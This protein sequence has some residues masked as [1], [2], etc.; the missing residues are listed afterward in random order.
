MRMIKGRALMAICGVGWMLAGQEAEAVTATQTISITQPTVSTSLTD[1]VTVT[2][3]TG[4]ASTSMSMSASLPTM[5]GSTTMT[6][7]TG[8]GTF[9]LS[10]SE[11][12]S[13]SVSVSLFTGSQTMSLFT[14]TDS[15]TMSL[16]TG[17]LTISLITGT[18][19]TTFSLPTGTASET[20]SLPTGTVTS[21][22]TTTYTVGTGSGSTTLTGTRSIVTGTVSYSLNTGTA[23]TTMTVPTGTDSASITLSLP[24]RTS[25]MSLPTGTSTTTMT[26][27]T[28]TSTASATISLP[29]GTQ[30]MS[31]T[32]SKS[33]SA[34]FSLP[35]LNNY[36]MSVEPA[37]FV[38][39]QEIRVQLKTI[40]DGV[41]SNSSTNRIQYDK[42]LFNVTDVGS[43][44]VRMYTWSS[45]YTSNCELYKG[46]TPLAERNEFGM[47]QSARYEGLV[48]V[49]SAH[50]TFPAPS[51]ATKFVI[52]FKHK[53]PQYDFHIPS[54]PDQM[55]DVWQVFSTSDG[56]YVFQAAESL[57]WYYLPDP[58]V[59]QYAIIQLLSQEPAWN[60]TYA[61]SSCLSTNA[62]CGWGDNLKIVPK[63]MACTYEYQSFDHAYLGS[64]F[65]GTDGS[66]IG[67]GLDSLKEGATA[68]GVGAFGTQFANPLV[69]TWTSWGT[70]F[71]ANDENYQGTS[72][73]S[74]PSG[75]ETSH[76]YAYVR[77][78]QT[79]GS[80][81]IC[82]SS[83]QQRISWKG[84]N[85]TIDSV[86]MW[87]K[88]FRCTSAA[89]CA[90]NDANTHFATVAEEVGWSMFDLSA[91][92]WGEIVFD[93]SGKGQLSNKAASSTV[94]V[95]SPMATADY[96]QVQTTTANYWAPAGG[97]YFRIVPSSQFTE[98]T[99]TPRVHPFT[100]GVRLGSFPSVGC[101]SR[102]YDVATS[103]ASSTS[104]GGQGG[105]VDDGA[106]YPIGS[107]DLTGDPTL[108]SPT[109]DAGAQSATY[110]SL[111]VPGEQEMWHVCYRRTC[112][113]SGATCAKNSGMRVLPF[114]YMGVGSTPTKWHHLNGNYP[115]T[116]VLAPGRYNES[117]SGAAAGTTIIGDNG[118]PP[119]VTWYTNDTRTET[120]GPIVVER[121]SSTQNKMKLDS[122]AWN[123]VRDWST[124]EDNL[125]MTVGST[126]RLVGYDKPC[127]YPGFTGAINQGAKNED[128]GMVECNSASAEA[129]DNKDEMWN[130]MGSASNLNSV[131]NMAFYITV[132]EIANYR[133][134]YRLGPWNWREIS[135]SSYREAWNDA[136]KPMPKETLKRGD[137]V[138]PAW[139]FTPTASA[140]SHLSL[141]VAEDR[142]QFEALFIV[143]DTQGSL[144]AKGR[145][146]CSGG[147]ESS[148]DVLRLVPYGSKCDINP[149]QWDPLL[150]D[151]HLSLY[152][153]KQGASATTTSGLYYD[154]SAVTP[155][156]LAKPTQEMCGGTCSSTNAM[157][158][159]LVKKTPDL[160]DDIVP[161]DHTY[162]GSSKL[163]ATVTIP[164]YNSV[165]AAKNFYTVCYKQME[166][167]NW[168]IFNN[169][170]EVK[171][172]PAMSMS[173][174]ARSQ[175]LVGGEFK[176]FK[177]T[178]TDMTLPVNTAGTG[179]HVGFYAKLVPELPH[180]DNNNC[181]NQPGDT[182][183]E[184]Y[185]AATSK[186]VFIAGG[187]NNSMYFYLTVPQKP[188]K[189]VLCVQLRKTAEDS[190]S[191]W[192]PGGSTSYDYDVLDNGIRWYV[193][194]GAQPTNNGLSAVKLVRCTPTDAG[195]NY[196]T[197][198]ETFNTNPDG[199]S[200]KI[201]AT[202]SP[203]SD[204]SSL[205]SPWGASTHVGVEG[206]GA[207]GVK[208]LGPNDGPADVAE[209]R[210]TLPGV[211][212]DA[213]VQY[214]VC[215][216]TLLNHANIG[217]A[218][219]PRWVEVAQ[220]MGM[221]EQVRIT[222][223]DTS[224]S[225]F[226]T[227]KGLMKSWTMDAAL[228]PA[229]SLFTGPSA[230][231]VGF[232]GASTRYVSNPS[233]ASSSTA[234]TVTTGF[235][236]NSYASLVTSQKSGNLFK[237]VKVGGPGTRYPEG[238]TW[239]QPSK[240]S[241]ASAADCMGPA[242]ATAS[243]TGTCSD[244]DGSSDTTDGS[245]VCPQL[246]DVA[247]ATT[248]SQ[249]EAVFHIPL[250]PGKYLVCYKV[251]HSSI[252][253]ENPWLWL[254]SEANNDYGLYSH[255]TFLE[256]EVAST[257]SNI[258]AFDL[259][260]MP[261]TSGDGSQV[262]VSS[263]CA[264][265]PQAADEGVPCS[266]QN[267][268]GFTTDLVTIV[269]DTQV[270][271]AP[272]VA[273]GGGTSSSGQ[274]G[275]RWFE[276][277]RTTNVSAGVSI[278]WSATAD[279]FALPP[280]SY[281][282][283][284]GQYKLCVYKAGE[285]QTG[286]FVDGA[287]EYVAKQGVVYQL[288]NRGSADNGGGSGFWRDSTGVGA[289]AQLLVTSTLQFNSSIRFMEY[290]ANL[291]T[292]YGAS[293]VSTD[294]VTDTM[295][296]TVSRTPLLRSGTSV[297]YVVQVATSDGVAIRSGSYPVDVMRCPR[298]TTWTNGLECPTSVQVGPDV[299]PG[300]FIIQNVNG[301]C[302]MANG[303][304]YGWYANG[305]RQFTVAGVVK[306][307]IQYRSACPAGEFGCGIRFVASAN[308]NSV[309]TTLSS[310]AQWVNIDTH[311]PLSVAING[312]EVNPTM[313]PAVSTCKTSKEPN[314]YMQECYHMK[315]CVLNFQARW[316]GPS[317]FSPNGTINLLYS[318]Q[319]Y[320][321]YNA[322]NVPSEVNTMLGS[323]F[324]TPPIFSQAP[325]ALG[326]TYTHT[327]TPNLKS[328][329]SATVYLN[330]TFGENSVTDWTRFVV[331][332]IKPIPK[333][334]AIRMVYPMDVMSGYTSTRS[335][336]PAFIARAP[337]DT[338]TGVSLQA[339]VGSYLEALIPYKLTY[340]PMDANGMKVPMVSG[341]LTGWT[342]TAKIDESSNSKVLGAAASGTALITE[343]KAL[344]AQALSVAGSGTFD[345]TFR[346]Y[347]V[348]GMCS[349]FITTKEG[350]TITFSF[351]HATESTITTSLRTPV[352]V[353]ASTVEVSIVGTG[354][355]TG[356]ATVR[357]G[358]VVEAR[359]GTWIVS[360]QNVD[361]FVYDEFH[362]GDIF[363]LL[364]SPSPTNGATNR[365]HLKIEDDKSYGAMM[366]KGSCAYADGD[367]CKVAKYR[368]Q[369]LSTT[370]WGA[371]WVMRPDKPC[372]S[373]EFTFHS[374][375]GAGPES[376]DKTRTAS[377]RGW[378][379][380][381]WTAETIDLVCAV[382]GSTVAAG[383]ATVIYFTSGNTA[384]ASFAVTVTAAATGTTTSA[385]Y[386]RW[387][388]FTD[389]AS[390]V[391]ASSG[392][393]TLNQA[394]ATG[395]VLSAKM[396]HG[397]AEF[398]DLSFAGSAAPTEGT[399]VTM[400]TTFHTVGLQ[401]AG[402]EPGSI[403]TG[404]SAYSCQVLV[405]LTYLAPIAA[406][407]YLELTQVDGAT[408]LCGTGVSASK[409]TD[410]STTVD[411]F[412]TGLTFHVA[413]KKMSN[414]AVSADTTIQNA[415]IVPLGGYSTSPKGVAPSWTAT[416]STTWTS[417]D[418]KLD[419]NYN[420]GGTLF[421]DG[422]Y[423][424]TYGTM[425]VLAVRSIPSGSTN[426]S[427]ADG[428]GS[429]KV[430]YGQT[431]AT[432]VDKSPVRAAIFQ[433]CN[434]AWDGS[435]EVTGSLCT[436]IRLW[437]LPSATVTNQLVI[438]SESSSGA[439]VRGTGS[440][441]GNSPDLVTAKAFA[442]YSAAGV[443]S[444]S[445]LRYFV[446][447]SDIEYSLA[448]KTGSQALVMSG[449]TSENT[450][451]YV[452]NTVYSMSDKLRHALT[453][454]TGL[455]VSFSFYGRDVLSTATALS[456]SAKV[457]ST[458]LSS[459]STTATYTW[460]EP[461]ETFAVWDLNTAVTM[462][463]ECP[464]KRRLQSTMY[465]YRT[466]HSNPPG[467]GWGY[468]MSAA[469]G[470]PFP[471]ETVVKTTAGS[472][473]WS[474][475]TGTMVKVSKRGWSGCNDGGDLSVY[476]LKASAASDVVATRDGTLSTSWVSTTTPLVATDRGVATAWPVF[477]AE[478]QACTLQLDLCYT[479]KTTAAT[480]SEGLGVGSSDPS[481]SMPIFSD[482]TKVT[483]PFSVK[484]PV[485]DLVEIYSQTT[486]T[487]EE[488]KSG[489]ETIYV[490]EMFKA[491]VQNVQVF[492]EPNRKWSLNEQTGTSAWT[493][494]MSV[495][496][497]WKPAAGHATSS[498]EM[499]YGNGGFMLDGAARASAATG[500]S[501]AITTVEFESASV[502]PATLTGAT[503]GSLSFFFARPCQSCEVWLDYKLSPPTGTMGM[504]L[505]GRGHMGSFPLRMY[506]TSGS[507]PMVGQPLV[508]MVKTCGTSWLL[509]SVPPVAVRR[510]TAFS[511]TALR[512]D[513]HNFPSW[514]SKSTAALSLS[515]NSGNGGG[516]KAVLTSPTSESSDSAVMA[517]EG[518][519]TARL[520]LTRACYHCVL[521]FAGVR[522][523]FTVLT[524][525]KQIIAIPTFSSKERTQWLKNVGDVG[526]WTY[527]IYAA[528]ELGDRSY[529][530]GGPTPFAFQPMYSTYNT[531]GGSRVGKALS[532]SAPA[533]A[534]SPSVTLTDATLSLSTLTAGTPSTYKIT[535]GSV[536]HN[537]IPIPS[538][539]NELGM[540]GTATVELSGDTPTVDFPLQFTMDGASGAAATFWGEKMTPK[541][542]WS[543]IADRM[544]V[545]DPASNSAASP[546]C[547][548][549]GMTGIGSC[550]FSAYAIARSPAATS[551]TTTWYK[552]VS[553]VAEN[554][555]ATVT[556]AA[557]AT[558]EIQPPAMQF[559]R[560]EVKF[561]LNILTLTGTAACS[562]DVTVTPPATLVNATA[563]TFTISATPATVLTS[564]VWNWAPST[565]VA[566][567]NGAANSI[568][569]RSVSLSLMA[570][571]STEAQTGLGGLTWA[572]NEVTFDSAG[573]TPTGCFVCTSIPMAGVCGITV[574]SAGGDTVNIAGIF[575]TTGTCTIASTAFGGFP[576]ASGAATVNPKQALAVDV[577]TPYGI[578][579]A[580][581]AAAMGEKETNFTWLGG[582]ID[583]DAAAIVG[584]GT[585]LKLKV[586]N[587]SGDHVMGD[588]HTEFT[589]T[590][591][592][593]GNLSKL[594]VPYW[595]TMKATAKGGYVQFLLDTN[596]TT[597]I[598][599]CEEDDIEDCHA[600]W[601]FNI[602]AS[603]QVYD[604][605]GL[606]GT[607]VFS[608]VINVGPLYFVRQVRHIVVVADIGTEWPPRCGEIDD[609]DMPAN[610]TMPPMTD[611]PGNKTKMEY[612]YCTPMDMHPGTGSRKL[613][614]MIMDGY[615][616]LNVMGTGMGPSPGMSM[617]MGGPSGD[618]GSGRGEKPVDG[619]GMDLYEDE[620]LAWVDM[621][622]VPRRASWEQGF[623]FK[624]K[625]LAF[626]T[627][628]EI[629][630]NP[631]DIGSKAKMMIRP[632]AV[633]CLNVDA[634][635]NGA[636]VMDTCIDGGGVC[637][638][639]RSISA[640]PQCSQKLSGWSFDS[641]EVELE[642]G[643]A[644][645][646]D[647]T[648]NGGGWKST[649]E[650]FMLTTNSFSEMKGGGSSVATLDGMTFLFEMVMQRPKAI[651]PLMIG[652]KCDLST[653]K[654]DV[655]ATVEPQMPFE[656]PAGIIDSF[657]Q[658]ITA[659]STSNITVTGKC[660]EAGVTNAFLG[661][662]DPVTGIVDPTQPL[663]FKFE[664]GM[665]HVR[666]IGV[667]ATCNKMEL[668]MTCTSGSDDKLKLCNG[669]YGKGYFPVANPPGKTSAP[670]VPPTP[671]TTEL[672]MGSMDSATFSSLDTTYASDFENKMLSM[673]KSSPGLETVATVL[674]E[675]V[676]NLAAGNSITAEDKK[677]PDVC[678][679]FQATAMP[680]TAAPV[681]NMSNITTGWREAE[682]LQTAVVTKA[683][684]Q[685][686]T[687]IALDLTKVSS[688][689]AA[690][691]KEDLNSTNSAL[692]SGSS[693]F[694]QA[695]GNGISVGVPGTPTPTTAIPTTN[696]PP[697]V[698]PAPDTTA[699]TTAVPTA[700]PTMAPDTP[701]PTLPNV[702]APVDAA[703]ALL[704]PNSLIVILAAALAAFM[705]L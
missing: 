205:V 498:V 337:A 191:W 230:D 405:D 16:P 545:D 1:S 333:S 693:T 647:I 377:G 347:V 298:A 401:Y 461:T 246:I 47:T 497:V 370:G 420:T 289:P 91:N 411:S 182:E 39:G 229:K 32:I 446:Y 368:T 338:A 501:A 310:A 315:P 680:T 662:V 314:C 227:A 433:I 163:A 291:E 209:M 50:V 265:P 531:G 117:V 247:T 27:P 578:L 557:C 276:L 170:W 553:N 591:M 624:M 650:R 518:S 250:T 477:S 574:D 38:E 596:I 620:W 270:C 460:K 431:G 440:S 203:C 653:K 126:L 53:L 125:A 334:V 520:F 173:P 130:C 537:G 320:V 185:A 308:I 637:N 383:S 187:G 26:L 51:M 606:I 505:A 178:L 131:S 216:R 340:E 274:P 233:T 522:H 113:F 640:L 252:T 502:M 384:S 141:M 458:S 97:D 378:K 472:R 158:S 488:K 600:P 304:G 638:T 311:P 244:P 540:V 31:H 74:A 410:W 451:L 425:D 466:Y 607:Q 342:V 438:T 261:S 194:A 608:D 162:F 264:Q 234:P 12:K 331:K 435:A 702:T 675:F 266:T 392:S 305:L 628:G 341:A 457:G 4:T 416:D 356:E 533:A 576:V 355:A 445:T 217:T 430:S 589:L 77:L 272:T 503:S 179:A 521:T 480:C 103:S 34:T 552:S 215:V 42:K 580:G 555:T 211:A 102:A 316:Q 663:V 528:D 290:A 507:I 456:I 672:D 404:T 148:G 75:G 111:Y 339:K 682:E 139:W 630:E 6:V 307:N 541:V 160:Y 586:L 415:T 85:S 325:W 64:L 294:L 72:V 295:T 523:H 186:A 354:S 603:A 144:A 213:Q 200:A 534:A 372:K 142:S 106:M 58:S 698:T 123:F 406:V 352:R 393:Y 681:V 224:K 432:S 95:S 22:G 605:T 134:C 391:T 594:E 506:T 403:P 685:V 705:L 296:G 367:D 348:D 412:T 23:S 388:V 547:M 648:F 683:Q 549:T 180:Q 483:K 396:D 253:T 49:Q 692:K 190:M 530:V 202:T 417:A 469:V 181:L 175:N 105:Y 184:A 70:Y 318:E 120:W 529:V 66:W 387:W 151:T 278:T 159:L 335:P 573:V 569:N 486:P 11:T 9:S 254:P 343:P 626:D 700:P 7:P 207:M 288:F 500:C 695:S 112:T 364:N 128:G 515:T 525:P 92:T 625:V 511:V 490:G 201:I 147:C 54:I 189:Y 115:Y 657:G 627:M 33:L 240:W 2:V 611:S 56:Q 60:F 176:K 15:V 524:D 155:C 133:V 107:R 73:V 313:A 400:T 45:T 651:F 633:P 453:Q 161:H 55:N 409:C 617:G 258:T 510:R 544:A 41:V 437:V 371:T 223:A 40:L 436:Q 514:D 598:D 89:A 696:Q 652:N 329:S 248:T 283:L 424:Y 152:C 157:L 82:F 263:W 20:I 321:G 349:R 218:G 476:E 236:F 543:P 174:L 366:V 226:Y 114:H 595:P 465:N 3:P 332:V 344:L 513:T 429:I 68:G 665:A 423:S 649:V 614:K 664:H 300:D 582:M 374:T 639:D 689:V 691:I 360:P 484:K 636:W 195:C 90:A 621:N 634:S 413:V 478:C 588:Y 635:N 65:V 394:G 169:T 444:T 277:I 575:T 196:A 220:A 493:R 587:Q 597:F 434:A 399:P 604:T 242:V 572:A 585:I 381:T 287:S 601:I 519:A 560:G 281:P 116:H 67:G 481:D 166:T 267:N 129:Q 199:D 369:A 293:V 616:I 365:D 146:K 69:D 655:N 674:L 206:G 251:M 14:G 353:L 346:V 494:T 622:L 177:M 121:T 612:M 108:A 669:K 610:E 539:G 232:A 475:T 351:A 237:L 135:P 641:E 212:S 474:F 532:L 609:N 419:S 17:S 550:Y 504:G 222:Y 454:T 119:L 414:G 109:N 324:G 124:P 447:D 459:V 471:I 214:K 568:L 48:Y 241:M 448:V 43:L 262:S 686:V 442:F 93:D 489:R 183:G 5:T 599:D 301:D 463:T 402:T 245:A 328:G 292:L 678:H 496:S 427:L 671:V 398:E 80:Y 361:T 473:A 468:E 570:W 282:S 280:V 602:S 46:M 449:S 98:T 390:D 63:G 564:E 259:R 701:V 286:Y 615:E 243:N 508:Y 590:G 137:W 44:Q 535:N 83:R 561:M 703:P 699:P 567:A 138:Q 546:Q 19:T 362:H 118:Y 193:K 81:D 165:N 13:E 127:D 358:L 136:T 592:R 345:F 631:G 317:E 94:I 373:C 495:R 593:D 57:A 198:Q 303:P 679:D 558:A 100:S 273:P 96:P 382:K 24:T 422:T 660:M 156:A 260:S 516:G 666:D 312:Q 154:S 269:N 279:A 467:M 284:S 228:Y 168:A 275:P 395:T 87:R 583:D 171:K 670:E 219:V 322:A 327:F 79:V 59:G 143:S 297:E 428:V 192:R 536:V 418:I 122:R 623:K 375:L 150:A 306:F 632:L 526:Q 8:T 52:C 204:G 684:F 487:A 687:A 407:S 479:G 462:D 527:E 110:A 704:A 21:T 538:V 86:P 559:W 646:E 25:T 697:P 554:V 145:K 78:P 452:K 556:C 61:P 571:D 302:S 485:V 542:D 512:V 455:E 101:W 326:G 619:L 470:Q 28:G 464:S 656:F 231:A 164:T 644:E 239:G 149:N 256:V 10:H 499:R 566:A 421:T 255:P 153:E 376:Y 441:C 309:A 330:V 385:Y 645:I 238:S 673:L 658:L 629:V 563:Q 443:T 450:T 357:N 643:K 62:K 197:N 482:R 613:D 677:N 389:T 235:K 579:P 336:A 517:Q 694:Q 221:A 690:A 132:P 439:K 565:T 379:T 84:E 408:G 208:N 35:A 88:L 285:A 76:A 71:P 359:P 271:P 99:S 676:C 299:S 492:G 509:G 188:G 668:T 688:K 667:T 18:D 323:T 210:V 319:D 140:L 659:D 225:A 581:P 37:S 551:A 618:F 397:V 36:T 257:K 29:T 577:M 548:A 30:S 491:D 584:E 642:E 562:C 661:K 386:P 426:S 654:C 363:A 350:C 104:R 249:I 172:A 167:S 380:L 268:G